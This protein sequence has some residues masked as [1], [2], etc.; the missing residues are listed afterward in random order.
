MTIYEAIAL[1]K[2][3]VPVRRDNWSTGKTLTFE[4]GQ[5]T[6]RAVAT[7]V[8]TGVRRTV[9][10]TDIGEQDFKTADWRTA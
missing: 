4:A 3:G 10:S 6:T 5:G 7:I 9:K 2:Q 1:A 8:E